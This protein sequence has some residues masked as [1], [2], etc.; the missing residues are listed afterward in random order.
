MEA[1]GEVRQGRGGNTKSEMSI[2][3]HPGR[4][5]RGT[6]GFTRPESQGEIRVGDIHLDGIYSHGPI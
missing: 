3:R 2:R 4:D 5:A 6:A 1:L